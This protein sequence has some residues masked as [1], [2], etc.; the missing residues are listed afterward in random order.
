MSNRASNKPPV[1]VDQPTPFDLFKISRSKQE[2]RISP[3][4]IRKLARERGLKIYRFGKLAFVS[5]T[6]LAYVL[7]IQ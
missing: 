6:D 1:S 4:T 2:V 5:R 7:K 3:N